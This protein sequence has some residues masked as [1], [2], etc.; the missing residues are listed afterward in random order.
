[1][2][3][4]CGKTALAS[5]K[6]TTRHTI[7]KIRQP[8]MM[9]VNPLV[10]G[11]RFVSP[12]EAAMF[13]ES[14]GERAL[15]REALARRQALSFGL[16]SRADDFSRGTDARNIDRVQELGLNY[17]LI[18]PS[19]MTPVQDAGGVSAQ[20]LDHSVTA[21]FNQG[22]IKDSFVGRA[23]ETVEKKMKA[24]VALGGN[25]PDSI[26]HNLK[27]QMKASETKASMEYRGLTNADL[28][29]SIAGRRTNLEIFESIATGSNIVFTHSDEPSDRR[30]VLS[31]RMNW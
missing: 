15:R 16:A 30:D 3:G 18:L 27:F 17:G 29:Y 4:T 26:K 12:L 19:S 20:I 22:F 14:E 31:L 13:D 11:P 5:I 9:R 10:H 28:S 21:F 25:Q 1:M 6:G 2:N 8:A 7:S 23:A 24:E